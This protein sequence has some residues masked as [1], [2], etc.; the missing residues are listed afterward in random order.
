MQQAGAPDGFPN[1]LVTILLVV[2]D[3]EG[4]I[5]EQPFYPFIMGDIEQDFSVVYSSGSSR[6]G[7]FVIFAFG[8][9]DLI[10][11]K[12]CKVMSVGN[13]CFFFGH[14]QMKF[15]PD[16]TA[17]FLFHLFCIVLTADNSY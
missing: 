14:F 5:G 7:L 9:C 4:I 6:L 2:F 13:Q 12:P 3:L 11:Q 16:K 17:Y 8:D 1:L 15:F 10:S